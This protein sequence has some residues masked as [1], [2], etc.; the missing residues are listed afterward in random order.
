MT[1]NVAETRDAPSAFA[2]SRPVP[3]YSDRAGRR[4]QTREP[5][6]YR[7]AAGAGSLVSDQVR[8]PLI[9]HCHLRWDFVWQ[10][11]QQLFSRL[12]AQHPVL[13]VEDP[14]HEA[15]AQASLRVTEPHPNVVRVVPVLPEAHPRDVDAQC[16]SVVP[17]LDAALAAHPRLAGRF[18]GAVQW[19]Y[20]PMTAP[21]FLGEFG[22]IGAVYDCMDELASFR[23]AP[24]DIVARERILLAEARVVFTG[25]LQLFDAKAPL[26]ANVHC[27]GCGVDVAHYAQAR[28]AAT[29]VPAEVAALPGPVLGYFGVIDERIDYELLE[30]L[31]LAFPQGSIAMVGPF[32]KVDPA[33]LP[34]LPNLHWLGQRDYSELPALVKG[35]DVCLMP[36]ALNEATRFINPTKTLEYM[37]AGKPIVSTAVPD[38]LRQFVPIVEVAHDH[39]AFIDATLRAVR[40]PCLELLDKGVERAQRATW[41]AIVA[42]MRGHLIEAF[43]PARSA[44]LP[45]GFV[46]ATALALGGE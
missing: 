38:V 27:F 30:R 40:A 3:P 7:A 34:D 43:R 39:D 31:A 37:A 22:T 21:V 8:R 5:S 29:A 19:F 9:V 24:A 18:G 41:E 28:D 16:A 12:A 44:S 32:A 36:F 46:G 11:P 42:A 17:L 13:F 35:F 33:S 25:G 26:H 10:R 6:T 20:S 4:A 1:R 23:F 45:G 2:E 14:V 15:V